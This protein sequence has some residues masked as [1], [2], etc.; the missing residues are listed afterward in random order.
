MQINNSSTTET[1]HPAAYGCILYILV[2]VGRI[3]ELFPFLMPLQL[4]KIS[5]LVA[6]IALFTDKNRD[7]NL[8]IDVFKSPAG[9]L[10]ILFAI[11]AIIGITY[12]VW[13]SNSIKLLKGLFL[14]NI[15]L[16]FLIVKSCINTKTIKAYIYC[17]LFCAVLLSLFTVLS[18]SSGRAA[19]SQTYDSNDLAKVL[20]IMLPIL[21]I[22]GFTAKNWIRWVYYAICGLFILAI[23]FTGSRGGL[24]S[25]VL[26]FA[27]L[28]VNSIPNNKGELKSYFATKVSIVVLVITCS[29][30]MFALLPAAS[31]KNIASLTSMEDDYNFNEDEG[32]IA[33]WTRTLEAVKRKP[34]GYGLRNSQV[35]EGNQ[36]G[37][38]KATH[39]TLLQIAAELGV[40]GAIIMILF[41]VVCWHKLS[42]LNAAIF[43]KKV[44]GKSLLILLPAIGILLCSPVLGFTLALVSAIIYIFMACLSLNIESKWKPRDIKLSTSDKIFYGGLALSLKASFIGQFAAS[45]FLSASYHAILY[46]TIGITSGIFS[47]YFNKDKLSVYSNT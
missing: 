15:I 33:I 2:T 35:V 42:M 10:L 21:L 28:F 43:N 16:F 25:L 29:G 37:R 44:P 7:K 6:V 24:I 4:G 47:F 20:V 39:N 1:L 9:K 17:L 22:V 31:M 27:F 41:Y 34:Y 45:F 3:P 12:S 26:G 18:G 14:S 8:N 46:A 32:R 13:I 40:L 38:F 23:L 19:A 36:G 30:F 11:V 5:I